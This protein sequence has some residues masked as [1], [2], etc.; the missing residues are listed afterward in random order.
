MNSKI[1]TL[2]KL[3][4][5]AVDNG[6]FPGATYCLIAGRKRYTGAVGY[7]ALLPKKEENYTD[8][9][10][11]MASVS[12][13]VATTTLLMQLLE[14][15][16]IRLFDK[17]STYLPDFKSE[18]ITIFDLM[19]HTSGLVPDIPK[20]NALTKADEVFDFAYKVP[21]K[22]AKGEKIIYS[23]IGFILLGKMIEAIL[24]MS[25]DRAAKLYI[26]S[27]LDMKDTTYNPKNVD[28]CAPTEK[29]ND[30]ISKELLRGKVHDEKAYILNGVAGH[31][32]VFS[33]SDDIGN[34]MEMILNDG[35]YKG[36]RVLSKASIDLLFTPQVEEKTGIMLCGS[37]RGL[38]WILKSDYP[39]CGDLASNNTILH[40]G[41]TGTNLF[42][43]RDNKIAFCMLSN[44]VHPTRENLKIIPFR[45]KLGNYI[46]ANFA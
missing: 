39:S 45:S 22:A 4:Q 2:N 26:F 33:T 21:L 6:V 14:N 44:R 46:I 28:R 30:A 36:K 3:M 7:K 16:K 35:V 23:D 40:T 31:A 17:V 10:Y 42:I 8:T 34:F 20:A 25:L 24:G 11:D 15:G 9:I 27:K 37:K 18:D 13:V 12:K 5:E 43:D 38:G 41:F 29:R 32:G 19:T 1:E